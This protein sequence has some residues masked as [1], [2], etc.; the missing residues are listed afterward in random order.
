MISFRVSENEFEQLRNQSQSHGVGSVSDYARLNLCR[1][2]H[3]ESPDPLE[4]RI[5]QLD[6]KVQT[7]STRVERLVSLVE[8]TH[9][10]VV[11]SATSPNRSQALP[12]RGRE[13][14]VT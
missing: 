7:L 6:G 11:N 10:A 13:G 2:Q 9:D 12:G 5:H 1:G 8:R 4:A 3:A 14:A